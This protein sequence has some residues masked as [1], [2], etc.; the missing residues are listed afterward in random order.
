MTLI[1]VGDFVFSRETLRDF[2]F[3][4]LFF[5]AFTIVVFVS[6]N[7]T[8]S[9]EKELSERLAD[10]QSLWYLD[11]LVSSN[12]LMGGASPGF[13]S[14]AVSNLASFFVSLSFDCG[15]E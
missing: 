3:D 8:R 12:R 14:R 5:F 10:R 6:A 1:F 2:D 9:A 13:E 4:L 15:F 11:C 7:L